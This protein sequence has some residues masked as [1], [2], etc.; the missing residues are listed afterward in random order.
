MSIRAYIVELLCIQY[1]SLPLEVQICM[2]S[3]LVHANDLYIL[4][5]IN[6]SNFESLNMPLVSEYLRNVIA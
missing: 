6:Q 3:S 5:A 2:D 4:L 1:S